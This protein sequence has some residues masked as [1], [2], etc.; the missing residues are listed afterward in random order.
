[1]PLDF[2]QSFVE[3]KMLVFPVVLTLQRSPLFSL[4]EEVD[5]IQRFQEGLIHFSRLA[6]SDIDMARILEHSEG[7]RGCMYI[8][9]TMLG[10]TRNT[11]GITAC[12]V[13]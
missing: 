11:S 12:F 9:T 8:H 10:S 2:A 1:M 6:S 5:V 13:N 7:H 4:W 3:M